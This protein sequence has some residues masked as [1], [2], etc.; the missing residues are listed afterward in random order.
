MITHTCTHTER[1]TYIDVEWYVLWI[2]TNTN[3]NIAIHINQRHIR[4]FVWPVFVMFWNHWRCFIWVVEWREPFQSLKCIHCI[5]L[6]YIGLF[7]T[8]IVTTC[9]HT[10]K[11]KHTRMNVL[12]KW[13]PCIDFEVY[14]FDFIHRHW[15][16][17]AQVFTLISFELWIL[18]YDC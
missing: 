8:L 9:T 2:A 18:Y 13:M 10:E 5:A 7:A 17:R 3:G 12:I 6:H 15:A 1:H 11:N 14:L 4:R 16:V